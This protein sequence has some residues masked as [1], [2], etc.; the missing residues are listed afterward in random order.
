MIALEW[1]SNNL[2]AEVER[3]ESREIQLP[4][5]PTEKK[6]IPN[7]LARAALFVPIG[8]GRRKLLDKAILATPKGTQIEF[9]GEQLSISDCDVYLLCL[10]SSRNQ[11]LGTPIRISKYD[12]L[13]KL[14]RKD[15]SGGQAYKNLESQ[16]NRLHLA[17]IKIKTDRYNISIHLIASIIE[18]KTN[19]IYNIIIDKDVLQLF[20][21]DEFAHIDWEKR[22]Q[23]KTAYKD[24]AKFLQTYIATHSK[25]YPHS[26]GIEQLRQLSGYTMAAR[27]YRSHLKSALNE[28]VRL[29]II[30]NYHICKDIISWERI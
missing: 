11:Q 17:Q 2:R 9:T 13:K 27:K 12:F 24:L 20:S 10:H 6:A 28:L 14:G 22:L 1:I 29:D 18:D 23:I 26:I 5:W 21:N 25:K 4:F 19:G 16:L 30:I 3:G 7:R 15:I 8:R